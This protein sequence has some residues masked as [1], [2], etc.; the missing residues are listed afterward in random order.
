MCQKSATVMIVAGMKIFIVH[1]I[2]SFCLFHLTDNGKKTNNS[3][4]KLASKPQCFRRWFFNAGSQARMPGLKINQESAIIKCGNFTGAKSCWFF[5]LP[6][7]LSTFLPAPDPPPPSPHRLSEY[8]MTGALSTELGR[9]LCTWIVTVAYPGGCIAQRK[10]S[11]FPPSS[12]GSNP[13]L[14]WFFLFLLSWCTVLRLNL[15]CAKQWISQMQLA[16]MSRAKY[17]KR[18]LPIKHTK[19]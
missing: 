3:C 2:R 11:C 9:L 8:L 16:M 7:N 18:L 5:Y 14:A 1:H 12:L 4:Q 17:Y 10:H 13:A 19:G 6:S 15:S